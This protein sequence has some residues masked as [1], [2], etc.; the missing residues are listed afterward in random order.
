MYTPAMP[1]QPALLVLAFLAAA[2]V[3]AAAVAALRPLAHRLG[4][5]DVPGGRKQH[6]GAVPLSGGAAL[7]LGMAMPVAALALLERTGLAAGLL[8]PAAAWLLG[9]A[10]AGGEA[11][12][13][14]LLLAGLLVAFAVGTADD[15][16]RERFP[17]WAK[18][19]GQFLAATLA[20]A[21]GARAHLLVDP[22]LNA[23]A[24]AVWIVTVI[25]AMNLLDH[26][27]G[28]AA[29]VGAIA[30]LLLG[31]VSAALGQSALGA[32]WM[33][34]A[35]AQAG[36]L[37]HNFPPARA[38]LGDAGAHAIGYLFGMLSLLAVYVGPASPGLV[39]VLLPP[40]VLALPLFDMALV[41]WMRLRSGQPV[42]VGDRNHIHHRLC[43]LGMSARQAT[44]TTW[45]AA[46]ALG[47]GAVALPF[48][49]PLGAAFILAQA[50]A[51]MGLIAAL[52][53]FGE[54][55]HPRAAPDAP[56]ARGGPP[57]AGSGPAAAGRRG[58]G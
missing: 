4:L 43:R 28:C 49:P 18:L 44:L 3:A 8:A 31:T 7:L 56:A 38:F 19:G 24:S 27:D 47:A 50:L 20:V 42:H 17:W 53:L 48:V 34:L 22:A 15:L 26:A 14:P 33:L 16:G 23:A 36:F 40:I 25:N 9:Q 29:G 2:A 55:P 58:A 32:L 21:G 1:Q 51:G 12:C 37:L 6:Q 46:F 54:Q 41:V 52:M 13:R 35:G 45:L 57:A 10:A 39:P 30:A 5:L 11:L